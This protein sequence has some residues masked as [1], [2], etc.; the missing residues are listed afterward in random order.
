MVNGEELSGA[1][2]RFS[3]VRFS[4]LFLIVLIEASVPVAHA[5]LLSEISANNRMSPGMQLTATFERYAQQPI[6]RNQASGQNE[7]AHFYQN[8]TPPYVADRVQAFRSPSGHAGPLAPPRRELYPVGFG[9][10]HFGRSGV[11]R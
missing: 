9:Q 7:N 10:N 11:G 5:D 3:I 4:L 6:P 2:F 1:G 8:W